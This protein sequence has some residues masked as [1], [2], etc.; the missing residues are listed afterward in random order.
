MFKLNAQNHLN[1]HFEKKNHIVSIYNTARLLTKLRGS[2]DGFLLK[3][4]IKLHIP[5][6]Y[7]K[8]CEY[9]SQPHNSLH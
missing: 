4:S 6:I 8:S 9:M 7:H 5:I 1:Q 3:C 2:A